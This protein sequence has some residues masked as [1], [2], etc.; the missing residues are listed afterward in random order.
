MRFQLNFMVPIR[1]FDFLLVIL[2]PFKTGRR[3]PRMLWWLLLSSKWNSAFKLLV[4][5]FGVICRQFKRTRWSLW[6]RIRAL[7]NVCQGS[8]PASEKLKVLLNYFEAVQFRIWSC[9]DTRSQWCWQ[10]FLFQSN[11]KKKAASNRSD[12]IGRNNH[13]GIIDSACI[14]GELR[15]KETEARQKPIK[16]L[17]EPPLTGMAMISFMFWWV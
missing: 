13:S 16:K 14:T 9:F 7:W 1:F 4:S 10:T 5:S 11:R 12:K 15:S 17:S 3:I 6:F 2:M 8:G